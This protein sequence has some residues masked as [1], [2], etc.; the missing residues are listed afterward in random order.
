MRYVIGIKIYDKEKKTTKEGLTV[1]DFVGGYPSIETVESIEKHLSRG[2]E[3]KTFVYH[4]AEK[5]Q[6][7]S[8]Q[9]IRNFRRDDVWKEEQIWQKSKLIITFYP[10]K[11]DNNKFPFLVEE[12][13]TKTKS[14]KQIYFYKLKERKGKQKC[15]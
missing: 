8:A 13:K 1:F 9:L 11:I 5:A 7:V 15:S 14:G 6:E 12:A 10:L 4:S 3:V 2:T